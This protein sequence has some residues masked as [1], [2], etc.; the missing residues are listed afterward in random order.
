MTELYSD[1]DALISA[2]ETR[3]TRFSLKKIATARKPDFP[4][5]GVERLIATGR[6]SLTGPI[7][8]MLLKEG[9]TPEN[10]R[11]MF[12][13]LS[14]PSGSGETR[15][16]SSLYY[17]T[18]RPEDPD[19]ADK[20]ASLTAH[21]LFR[22]DLGKS[23]GAVVIAGSGF[24]P[25]TGSGALKALN[26]ETTPVDIR[27]ALIMQLAPM[28]D[29]SNIE[30]FLAD[31]NPVL[32]ESAFKAL[33][34]GGYPLDRA[35][36]TRLKADPDEFISAKAGQLFEG[37]RKEIQTD[38][39]YMKEK[40]MAACWGH[41]LGDVLGAQVESLP[42]KTVIENYGIVRGFVKNP[43]EDLP[44]GEYTDDTDMVLAQLDV[45]G[46]DGYLDPWNFS[47]AF[48]KRAYE[49]DTGSDIRRH[50][51]SRTLGAMRNLYAGVNWRAVG[52]ESD[53]NG[54]AIRVLPSVFLNLDSA[55]NL[56][57]TVR[58]FS[59][60]T[61]RSESAIQA[62]QL[63]ARSL[64]ILLH[65]DKI[66]PVS[67]LDSQIYQTRDS[68]LTDRLVYIRDLLVNSRDPGYDEL[69]EKIGTSS[70]AVQ[71]V[72]FALYSFLKFPEDFKETVFFAVN[73]AGD[74]DSI[75]AMASSLSGAYLGMQGIPDELK[76]GIAAKESIERILSRLP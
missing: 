39:Q 53:R 42:R 31:F 49:M 3:N 54:A 16:L 64:F 33:W 1:I 70:K 61:H 30:A 34:S 35:A 43:D 75:A 28:V 44:E 8:M 72:P 52:S 36:V 38:D 20:V 29:M 6:G 56:D 47:D 76:N 58:R 51:G 25:E 69:A 45:I 32:R 68:L 55:Q 67:F 10:D 21:R 46:R 41:V 60:I 12:P 19:V 14:D 22:P 7:A 37:R 26:S 73:A 50:Y 17:S 57:A 2:S 13:L 59:S 9:V 66:D 24:Y 63:L 74:V 40:F 65:T 27:S 62:A 18:H 23:V 15:W 71:S 5:G 48:G 11:L 4:P